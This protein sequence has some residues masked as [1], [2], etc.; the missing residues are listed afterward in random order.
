MTPKLRTDSVQNSEVDEDVRSFLKQV[1]SLKLSRSLQ[2]P[3][4]IKGFRGKPT[5]V[6][7]R[8]HFSL[9]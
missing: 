9:D 7:Q 3:K 8:F 6:W 5:L 2:L 4:C 1:D